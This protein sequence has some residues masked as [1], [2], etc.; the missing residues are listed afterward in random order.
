MNREIEALE[1]AGVCGETSRI[2]QKQKWGAENCSH[3]FGQILATS[4]DLTPKGSVLE[5]KSS[6]F[7]E[8]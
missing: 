4:H 1:G 2:E 6:H 3:L 5:G 8:I 7:R